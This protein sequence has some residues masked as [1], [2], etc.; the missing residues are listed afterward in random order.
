MYVFHSVV[1]ALSIYLHHTPRE[2]S[3]VLPPPFQRRPSIVNN[4]LISFV[5]TVITNYTV[6]NILYCRIYALLIVLSYIYFEHLFS[7]LSNTQLQ[8]LPTSS[9]Q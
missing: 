3:I 5:A 7:A 8:S 1:L 4:F 6:L 9:E 2:V